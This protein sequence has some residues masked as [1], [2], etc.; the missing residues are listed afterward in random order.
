MRY[1]K[2]LPLIL[3]FLLSLQPSVV[4][5]EVG[6]SAIVRAQTTTGQTAT[7]SAD[8]VPSGSRV[9]S[10]EIVAVYS[11][12]EPMSRGQVDIYAPGNSSTPWRRGTLSQ[13]GR[14]TF[15]PDLSQRGRWTVRVEATGHRN[16]LNIIL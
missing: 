8:N 5:H 9:R 6:L 13:R 14:Y 10:I 16:F 12:G 4:A 1:F 2:P 7:Y 3:G 11:T 15:T